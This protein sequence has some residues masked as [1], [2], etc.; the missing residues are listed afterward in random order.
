MTPAERMADQRSRE[1]RVIIAE[2]SKADADLM[3]RA[4]AGAGLRI[5]H[6]VVTSEDEF[7][8]ALVSF[9]P[10]IVLTDNSMPRFS[11]YLALRLSRAHDPALPVIMV[12]GTA[13]EDRMI[14][15]LREGLAN[16]ILKDSLLRLPPAVLDA[17][18]HA[19]VQRSA[20]RDR[21]ALTA[22]ERRFRAVAEASGDGLIIA[23]ELGRVVFWNAAASRLFGYA[24]AEVLG[25]ELRRMVPEAR[26]TADQDD[27][28]D[29]AIRPTP[30][31]VEVEGYRAN[32]SAVPLELTASS[33]EEDGSRYNSVQL[34]D[35]TSRKEEARTRLV[36]SQVIE[37]TASSVIITD[38][39]GAIQYANPAFERL[40]GYSAAEVRGQTP[41]VLNSGIQSVTVYERLWREIS[42]G[43]HFSAEFVNRRK[44][45]SLFTQR[46]TVFPIVG[47]HGRIER[48]VGLGVDVT[49]ER[50]LER[51]L[52][53]A[54]K[55]EAV[56]QLVGGIA[57]DFNNTLTGVLA[58]AALLEQRLAVESDNRELVEEVIS[59]ARRGADLVKR[60]MTL[61]RGGAGPARRVELPLAVDEAVRTVRRVLP[62]HIRMTVAH[63]AGALYCMLDEGELHQALLNLCNNARD[64]MPDGGTLTLRTREHRGRAIIEVRDSGMGMEPAVLERI[65]D[66]FFTTKAPGKGTGLGLPMVYGFT[67]HAGGS[68][69]VESTPGTGT[70]VRLILPLASAEQVSAPALAATS[71]EAP[72]RTPH[73]GRTILLVEDQEDLRKI[74]RRLLEGLGY[75]VLTAADGEEAMHLL[76]AECG[77]LD[78]VLSD[79]VLP[80]GGA[81]Q[82]YRRVQE[83]EKPPRFLLTS[84][85]MPSDMHGVSALLETVPFLPKPW[86]IGDLE[87]AVVNALEESRS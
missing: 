16:Y 34:R 29:R 24:E 69:E 56:G 42:H 72:R 47:E 2:D 61:S 70:L 21:A 10:D 37:Q 71:A 35:I 85:Y 17:L 32:G 5:A 46:T 75:R 57:H 65:F 49:S 73:A 19:E 27:A 48:F 36:L 39:Q 40:T 58:N 8:A 45:G 15:L 66:P 86:T 12:S 59:A 33:W 1:I 50:T 52:R 26:L 14:Q 80:R 9:R 7:L 76:D 18:D 87:S 62:E 55:M 30:F 13:R 23:D 6:R 3:L 63:D 44:D 74:A 31:T 77:R 54:Q 28:A 4:L 78:L 60:L 84:G 41:R 64:A 38:P 22:S 20:A 25:T 11:G 81:E 82:L 68:I 43:R 67:K 53:Q 79:V 51:Q 83:W